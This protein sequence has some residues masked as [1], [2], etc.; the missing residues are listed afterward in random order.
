MAFG[1]LTREISLLLSYDFMRYA[2]VTGALIS[3]SASLLGV[4]LVLKRYSMIGDGLAHVGFGAFALTAAIAPLPTWAAIPIVGIAAILLLRLGN[5]GRIKGDALIAVVS[6]GSLAGGLILMNIFNVQ[7]DLSRYMFGSIFALEKGDVAMSIV[8]CTT[9]ILLYII[10]Y[11]KIFLISFDEDFARAVGVNISLYNTMLAVLTAVVIVVGMR[12]MG[13]LLISGLVIFPPLSAMRIAGKFKATV[14]LSAA[15]SVVCFTA[16]LILTY[17]FSLPPGACIVA[18]NLGVL[19]L[20][21]V[22]GR[23][24]RR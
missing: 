9:I 13:A 2:F 16:G 7:N 15:I 4:N 22:F 23:F 21:A 20:L 5:S 10:F 8:A 6:L 11:N 1:N 19:V 14:F 18:V 17:Y 24:G 3:L 12:L